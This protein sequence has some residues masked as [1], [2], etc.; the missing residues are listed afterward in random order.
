MMKPETASRATASIGIFV[1]L[2]LL[3]LAIVP[4]PSDW[5]RVRSL[6]N[7]LRSPALSHI[8][9]NGHAAGYYEGLLA[10]EGGTEFSQGES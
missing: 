5:V 9:H 2:G 1:M 8:E 3:A 6:I 10:G 4:W 7:S